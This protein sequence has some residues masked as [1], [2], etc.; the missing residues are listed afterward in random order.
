MSSPSSSA[1]DQFLDLPD[2]RRLGYAEYG[3]SSGRPVLF[4]H[5]APGS[6]YQVHVDMATAAARQGVRLIAPER[7][8]FGLSD[9][10]PSRNLRD[11]VA[12]VKALTDTLGIERFSIVAFSIGGIYALVCAHDMPARIERIA[13]ASGLAPADVPGLTEGRS[14]ELNGLYALAQSD[15]QGLRAAMTPL[16]QS[17]AGLLAAMVEP[18]PDWDK[19]IAGQ[20]SGHFETDFA[21]ALR[22]GVDG[23]TSDLVLA[24]RPWNFSPEDIETEVHIWQG[25]EDRNAPP[26]MA[27][28]LAAVLPKCELFMLPSE[29]HLSLFAHGDEILARLIH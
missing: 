12:D 14:P 4:F 8:G 6:R 23:I 29:G 10:H 3:M 27:K 18:M 17:P 5:G 15:P 25:T 28:Y 16:A 1:T 11:W 13:Q 19:M 7:P 20:L 26:A 2:G 21:E 24:S 9:P 22:N